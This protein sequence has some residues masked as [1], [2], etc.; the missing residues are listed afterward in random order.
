MHFESD[1]IRL[2]RSAA[3]PRVQIVFAGCEEDCF[4]CEWSFR[5]EG[6]RTSRPYGAVRAFQRSSAAEVASCLLCLEQQSF[7]QNAPRQGE[8][9]EGKTRLDVRVR[10][11][12]SH[13]TESDGRRGQADRS[14]P[15]ADIG[16]PRRLRNSPQT[17]W[18]AHAPFQV[19]HVAACSSKAHG[20]HRTPRPPPITRLSTES[21]VIM[22]VS[23]VPHTGDPA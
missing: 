10:G 17:L 18:W 1:Q 7:V 2:C 19:A 23:F 8:S 22:E 13:T 20:D 3:L 14:R 21:R 6:E 5:S 9:G 12:Q 15:V 16:R 4:S 11:M